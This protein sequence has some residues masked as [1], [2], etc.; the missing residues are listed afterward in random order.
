MH[1]KHHLENY[2]CSDCFLVSGAGHKVGHNS[3]LVL[4]ALCLSTVL[5][6]ISRTST[7]DPLMAPASFTDVRSPH[8]FCVTFGT[9]A[10][11][12]YDSVW[13]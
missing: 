10:L 7:L 12:G 11:Q 9:D 4:A 1:K 6:V 2:S 3:L 13:R 8:I 5:F